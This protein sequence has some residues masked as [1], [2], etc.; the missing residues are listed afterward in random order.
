MFIFTLVQLYLQNCCVAYMQ[1]ELDYTKVIQYHGTLVEKSNCRM[2]GMFSLWDS[3]FI[4]C[5]V[6]ES[7][8][9]KDRAQKKV[10]NQFSISC[11]HRSS[12]IILYLCVILSGVYIIMLLFGYIVVIFRVFYLLLLSL[13][14][15]FILLQVKES[16]YYEPSFEFDFDE[17]E[18]LADMMQCYPQ[19]PPSSRH[20]Q[21]S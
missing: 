16:P 15:F 7:R 2:G 13:L 21:V 12:Y 1:C 20:F 10:R 19:P 4:L 3:Q 6:I 11:T 8:S 9:E 17:L 18:S 5:S 14:L